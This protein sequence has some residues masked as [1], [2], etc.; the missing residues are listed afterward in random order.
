MYVSQLYNGKGAAT[1]RVA[2]PSTINVRV[3]RNLASAVG[4]SVAYTFNAEQGD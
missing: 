4:A 1:A 2:I 3:D